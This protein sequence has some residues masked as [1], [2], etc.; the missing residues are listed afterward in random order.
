MPSISK[1]LLMKVV[2][3]T[4]VVALTAC[5]GSGQQ[6]AEQP[7]EATVEEEGAERVDSNGI[8]TYRPDTARVYY[9]SDIDVDKT[10]IVISKKNL[11][12]SVY[13]DLATAT[14]PWWHAILCA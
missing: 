4:L 5:S 7:T 6:G 3:L 8:V 12:L 13:A 2:T 9:S 11:Q 1:K 10:F 14:R